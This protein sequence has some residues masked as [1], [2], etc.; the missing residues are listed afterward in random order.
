[1]WHT[2]GHGREEQG[3]NE[4]VPG[5]RASNRAYLHD[6]RHHVPQLSEG[7]TRNRQNYDVNRVL[8]HRDRA[9]L[10]WAARGRFQSRSELGLE[11]IPNLLPSGFQGVYWASWGAMIRPASDKSDT[12]TKDHRGNQPIGR[13]VR[14]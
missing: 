3:L 8:R 2:F 14:H 10:R 11:P 1:M 5:Y 9:T 4:W 12:R 7:P 13:V 6:V